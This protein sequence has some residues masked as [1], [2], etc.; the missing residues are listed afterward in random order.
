MRILIAINEKNGINSKLSEHFGHCP[1]FA[2]YETETNDLEF[3]ENK[4]DHSDQN[5]TPVDQ[6]MK[7][8]PNIVFTLGAGQ[9][10]VNLFKEKGVK[11][12]TGKYEIVKEVIENI[13]GLKDL[14]GGCG[15]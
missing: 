13:E 7:F 6:M 8:N 4:I 3:V 15:H 1:Y 10:A 9:R 11:L 14:D 2:I 5:S 12:K